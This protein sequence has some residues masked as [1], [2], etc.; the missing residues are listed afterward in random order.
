P[1]T[2]PPQAR[3]TPKARREDQRERKRGK[4]YSLSSTLS[5]RPRRSPRLRRRGDLTNPQTL[6]QSRPRAARGSLA[7]SIQI[8]LPVIPA[9]PLVD[10]CAS[11]SP[12]LIRMIEINHQ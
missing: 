5:A 7:K 10:L 4:K 1:S 2:A 3:R 8:S 6:L 9:L 11:I 12:G